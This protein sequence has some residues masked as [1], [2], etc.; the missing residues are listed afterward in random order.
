VGKDGL[1]VQAATVTEIIRPVSVIKSI[2]VANQASKLH[3]LQ[4]CHFERNKICGK[5][6]GSL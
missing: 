4:K 1:A 6:W 2:G 3:L 5:G